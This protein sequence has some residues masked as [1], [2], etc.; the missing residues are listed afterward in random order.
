VGKEINP[1]IMSKK[2]SANIVDLH[3]KE[4]YFADI[5]VVDGTIA[6]IKRQDQEKKDFPYILPGFVDAHVHIES[7]MLVPTKFGEQALKHGTVATVS[8]PHEIANVLGKEGVAYMVENAQHTPLKIY[9]GVPSCVP[10]TGFETAGASLS[11]QEIGELFDEY[12]LLYLSEMMN[13]PGV[14]YN[15]SDVLSKLE[16]AKKRGKKIDGHAP[17]IH[18]ADIVNYFSKGITTD[19]ECFSLDEALEKAAFGVHILIREG[20]AAKNYEAL[21]PLFHSHPSQLMFCSDDKHP[22][23]LI[24][25][26]INLLVKRALQDGFD[27]FDVLK[28]AS[29]N[30]VMHYGLNVGLLRPGD[31]ADFIL[32]DDPYNLQILQT[33]INGSPV[34]PQDALYLDSARQIAIVNQFQ[35]DPIKPDC[36]KLTLNDSLVKVI[37]ALDGEL[38]TKKVEIQLKNAVSGIS[39]HQDVLKL[40]VLNRYRNSAPAIA[41]IKGFG[42]SRGALASTVAHD[43]HNIIAVGTT[44]EEIANAINLLIEHRGGI[45]ANDGENALVLSLPIAGLMSDKSCHE[46]AHVYQKLDQMAKKMGSDLRAPYMTL[47]FMALLVIPELKLSD[48]GLFDGSNFAFTSLQEKR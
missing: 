20:S 46:V 4:I 10:A 15:D 34:W 41:L 25:G 23:D 37:Q 39:I 28:A 6:K 30:P 22:D 44:D 48:L 29:L 16:E 24:Q 2:L 9:F 47:S 18:G 35:C 8:D 7:S 11:A 36:L 32:V 38:I 27:Y 40:V 13:Y 14:I 5:E 12:D 43:C 17:G 33:W 42:L 19:H 3:L 1:C 31:P 45:T 26:H 21:K